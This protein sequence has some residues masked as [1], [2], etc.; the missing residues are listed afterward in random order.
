MWEF[1]FLGS[2]LTWTHEG[3]IHRHWQDAN[4]T[5]LD[6][7]GRPMLHAEK[8]RNRRDAYVTV[9]DTDR[10]QSFPQAGR[11]CSM[12]RSK[13]TG[14]TPMLQCVENEDGLGL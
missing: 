10:M 11:L 4:V 1:D 3:D 14:G 2:L 13:E 5:V 12:W 6:T 8:Q 9:A 7:G